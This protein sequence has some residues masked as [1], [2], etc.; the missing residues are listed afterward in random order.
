MGAAIYASRRKLGF[1][2]LGY[3]LMPDHFH[4]L[5]WAGYPLTISR[6]IQDFKWITSRSVNR[7]RQ[8]SGHLWQHQFWDRFVR[9]A[10]ELRQRLDYMHWNPLRK[11][12]MDRQE[13]WRWSSY[14]NFALDKEIVE[15]CPMQFDY[16]QL[17]QSYRG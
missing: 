8:T 12:L 13:H 1:L 9:H 2:L 7:A 6:V 17:P 10:R 5:L 14:N 15:K 4:A 3:V 11:G 16:G